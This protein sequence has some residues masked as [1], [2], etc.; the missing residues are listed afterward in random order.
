[1]KNLSILAIGMILMSFAVSGFTADIAW[2]DICAGNL[3]LNTVSVN[4]ENPRI[5]Y[6]GSDN[7][8]FKTQD[9]GASWR[10]VLLIKGQNKKV[11]SLLFNPGGKDIYAATGNGLFYSPNQGRTWQRV[12]KGKNYLEND[13]T[14]I[15]V[16][17]ET[18]YLGTKQG[19]FNSKDKGKTWYKAGGKLENSNITA[20]TAN[21]NEPGYVYAGCSDGVFISK[22]RGQTWER[23]LTVNS[24]QDND[25]EEIDEKEIENDAFFEIRHLTID[26]KNP[27]N[28]YLATSKGVYKSADKG[29]NWEMFTDYGL[30]NKDVKFL[31]ITG[32]SELYAASKSDVFAYAKGRWHEI[33][34]NMSSKNVTALEYDN[35]GNLYAACDNGLF[36]TNRKFYMDIPM[37][38]GL[39]APYDENEPQIA[40]VQKAAVIYAEV[41]PEKILRWRNQA[42]KKAL[43]PKLSTGINRN[44]SDLRHWETGSTSKSGDDMLQRGKDTIEWDITLSWDLGEIIWTNDQTSIDV[45]SRLMVQLRDDVLD[46]VTKLYFERIRVKMELDNLSIEDRKKRFEKELRLQ[47][48]TAYLDG[49][50]GGY[51]SNQI[52]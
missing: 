16:S 10:N 14:A 5:I 11:N 30:L 47:E 15:Y 20:I 13:C 23:T 3:R 34:L 22:D 17:P 27:D 32:E 26:N 42:Q 25:Y 36:K 6:A 7:A 18:I 28:I 45:R 19:L 46:E 39:T 51:F 40:D 50:T 41:E 21:I 48:L 37:E 4:R 9:A 43:L 29:Q 8:V 31:L 12:F 44:T 33:S 2:E 24:S 52:K 35:Q 49:L 1:M 38:P